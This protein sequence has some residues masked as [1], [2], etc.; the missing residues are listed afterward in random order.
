MKAVTKK[1]PPKVSISENLGVTAV[2]SG[3]NKPQNYS[4]NVNSVATKSRWIAEGNGV[5]GL[6]GGL[7]GGMI[8]QPLNAF[9][10]PN[11]SVVSSIPTNGNFS[12]GIFTITHA[13]TVAPVTLVQGDTLNIIAD[14]INTACGVS[15]IDATARVEKYY[16]LG[17][18]EKYRLVLE[19]DNLGYNI[20][21]APDPQNIAIFTNVSQYAFS[22]NA[23]ITVNNLLYE[24]DNNTF[25]NIAGLASLT[26]TKNSN[27]TITT[28]G[29]DWKQIYKILL[30]L[31][32]QHLIL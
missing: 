18:V 30:N 20:N 13:N 26:V 5:F 8:N 21:V 25:T 22:Q 24:S 2:V 19:S 4:V 1:S 7:P 31:L 16:S 28:G 32:I 3:A 10:S 27:G 6:P 12:L 11:V 23:S 29:R 14:K 9:P 17:D 15:G